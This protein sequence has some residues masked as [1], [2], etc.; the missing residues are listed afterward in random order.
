M[1]TLQCSNEPPDFGGGVYQPLNLLYA[2]RP[3][4]IATQQNG[5]APNAFGSVRLCTPC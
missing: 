3:Y 4:I 1:N 5:S 2:D